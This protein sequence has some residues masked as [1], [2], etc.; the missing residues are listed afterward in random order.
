MENKDIFNPFSLSHH[1]PSLVLQNVRRSTPAVSP[2]GKWAICLANQNNAFWALWEGTPQVTATILYIPDK[3]QWNLSLDQNSGR[4]QKKPASIEFGTERHEQVL[5]ARVRAG[6][7]GHW[8]AI[9]LDAKRGPSLLPKATKKDLSLFSSSSAS[10]DVSMASD[11]L[12]APSL[13]EV[14][15]KSGKVILSF[16]N[17]NPINQWYLIQGAIVTHSFLDSKTRITPFEQA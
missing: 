4:V 9:R 12:S 2:D 10:V 5:V 8:T 17:Q 16:N 6:Y 7:S 15:S 13:V 3:K 11:P 1:G 14:K